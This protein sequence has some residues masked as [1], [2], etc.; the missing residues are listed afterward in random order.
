MA[1][2][3]IT[4]EV[5]DGVGVIT[6][7]RPDK[8]N[9]FTAKMDAEVGEALDAANADDAVRAIVLTGAGRGFCAGADMEGL[10]ATASDGQSAREVG[11]VAERGGDPLEANFNLRFSR[12]MTVD[13]PV[14]AALNGPTAGIGF[15]MTL[16]ADI[17]I[18]A[19]SAFALTAFAHRGLIAEWGCSWL[20]PHLIGQSN[21]RD[22]LFSSRRVLAPELKEMGF[23]SQVLPD[24]GFLDAVEAY[25]KAMVEKSSPRSI[26]IMK[27]Q[28][29]RSA[30][31]SLAESYWEAYDEMVAS[32]GT[33][34][35]K[36]GV[37]HFVEKRPARFTGR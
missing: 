32:F 23:V 5:R 35:F 3:Q 1:Y 28:L 4:Y 37:A 34:D 20:L 6:L 18:A 26:R 15:V 29:W 31:Q 17:R 36:E 24:A 19:E 25:A 10:S 27:R 2:E 30:F 13:K 14:I 22:M 7:N 8:L 21:A 12:M 11:R 16:Y 33:E 9:A